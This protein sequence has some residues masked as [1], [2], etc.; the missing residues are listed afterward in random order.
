M[1]KFAKIK[2]KNGQNLAHQNKNHSLFV[3]KKWSTIFTVS[4]LK[5]LTN[6][7]WEKSVKSMN[8]RD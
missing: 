6:L 2:H 5:K 1:H 7:F 3:K 4:E 8:F